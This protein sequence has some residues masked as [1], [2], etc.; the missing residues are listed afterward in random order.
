MINEDKQT[1]NWS[2]ESEDD[3]VEKFNGKY[4]GAIGSKIWSYKRE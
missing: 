2:F 1:A 3:L 4:S